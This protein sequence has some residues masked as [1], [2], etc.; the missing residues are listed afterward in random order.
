[1]FSSAHLLPKK[2]P[3]VGGGGGGGGSSTSLCTDTSDRDRDDLKHDRDTST[4]NSSLLTNTDRYYNNDDDDEDY[5]PQDDADDLQLHTPNIMTHRTSSV[6]KSKPRRTAAGT[7]RT[8]KATANPNWSNTQHMS[9]TNESLQSES[10]DEPGDQPPPPPIKRP[11]RYNTHDWDAIEDD[12][13]PTDNPKY[14]FICDCAITNQQAENDS[15]YNQLLEFLQA[16]YTKVEPM[17]YTLKA[18]QFYNLAL[19]DVTPGKLPWRRR[20][21]YEHL[22]IHAPDLQVMVEEPL[23]VFNDVLRELR[24]NGIYERESREDP[25]SINTEKMLLYM[26]VIKERKPLLLQA[27]K[28]RQRR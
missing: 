21:I 28:F 22:H 7:K 13:E 17:E 20:I 26:K 15:V 18:Q 8:R 19:R 6:A 1:M 12:E 25:I 11:C 10:T 3:A 24:D 9:F 5:E 27:E 4:S 23:R 2:L 16:S 14:C